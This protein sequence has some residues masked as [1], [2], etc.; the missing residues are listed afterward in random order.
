M[1]F[2]EACDP[3]RGIKLCGT[4]EAVALPLVDL[5]LIRGALF[6]QQTLYRL[7]MGDGDDAIRS[8]VQDK[9]WRQPWTLAGTYRRLLR[10][11]EAAQPSKNGP[12]NGPK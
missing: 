5:D 6:P 10:L 9:G 3:C 2:K 8:T 1:L 11:R 7:S 4:R 12:L